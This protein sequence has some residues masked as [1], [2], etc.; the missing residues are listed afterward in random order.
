[1][2]GAHLTRIQQLANLAS[3]RKPTAPR[4]RGRGVVRNYHQGEEGHPSFQEEG[5]SQCHPILWRSKIR[6]RPEMGIASHRTPPPWTLGTK[7]IWHKYDVATVGRYR[8]G[9]NTGGPVRPREG[10]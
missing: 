7:N 6:R 10:E 3:V 9:G 4:H 8:D 5:W 2:S 1:M